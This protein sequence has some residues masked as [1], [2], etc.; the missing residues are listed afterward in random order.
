MNYLRTK[1]DGLNKKLDSLPNNPI[2]KEKLQ[3]Y[4]SYLRSLENPRKSLA[5]KTSIAKQARELMS[6]SRDA[7]NLKR[8]RP[9]KSGDWSYWQ[10][11]AASR[12]K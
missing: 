7:E 2:L 11:C 1:I 9:I 6:A 10:K 5:E 8:G 4:T 12:K 3:L